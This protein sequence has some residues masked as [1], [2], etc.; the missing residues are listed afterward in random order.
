M[1]SGLPMRNRSILGLSSPDSLRSTAPW[2]SSSNSIRPELLMFL[3][4]SFSRSEKLAADFD[5]FES[6][7]TF[8]RPTDAFS[9]STTDS[10]GFEVLI[11]KRSISSFLM[12]VSVCTKILRL[13]FESADRPP[14]RPAGIDPVW[15]E[16]QH[17]VVELL[18]S[19]RCFRQAVEI[20]NV[21]PS[22]FDD[23]GI[24]AVFRPL[25]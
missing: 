9:A 1:T 19:L 8:R 12:A 20:A 23:P 24:V 10:N 6:S 21:L 18:S 11:L 7:P 15:I 14:Q 5:V 22:L 25:M 3:P 13:G 2:S 16:L 17:L 4:I